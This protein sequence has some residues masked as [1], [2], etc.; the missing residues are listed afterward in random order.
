MTRRYARTREREKAWKLATYILAFSA[1]AGPVCSLL[2]RVSYLGRSTNLMEILWAFSIVLESMCVVPQL[3]L[4]RQTQV[5]TVINSGYLVCLGAYRA[6]YILNWLW[7][8]AHGDYP[9]AISVV[10]GIIQTALYVDF[11][12]VY[13]TRQRVKLRGGAVVDS[14]DLNKGFLVNR[15]ARVRQSEDRDPEALGDEE[16]QARP[17]VNNWGKRGVSI[18]A[19]DT[20]DSQDRVQAPNSSAENEPLT[21]PDHFMSDDEHDDAPAIDASALSPKWDEERPRS[22]N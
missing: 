6:L 7:R 1:V 21:D 2:Y 5:P 13:Y 20:L 14:D 3:L 22:P 19:D 18:R 8:S 16:Q 9:D 4:L 11:A 17:K 12:W 10:F 15:F